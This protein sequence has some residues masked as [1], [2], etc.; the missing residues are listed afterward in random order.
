[1]T[2]TESLIVYA[3]SATN[4]CRLLAYLPQILLLLRDRGP[5]TATSGLSWGL[6][7]VSNGATALYAAVVVKRRWDG[8]FVCGQC[9]VLRGHRG[10]DSTPTAAMAPDRADR[11]LMSRSSG[12][13]QTARKRNGLSALGVSVG[14]DCLEA[15]RLRPDIASGSRSDGRPVPVLLTSRGN[16]TAC[17]ERVELREPLPRKWLQ[18]HGKR[19]LPTGYRAR[20]W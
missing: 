16:R 4:F 14:P 7:L 18:Q 3:F 19:P 5:A 13:R 8:N 10:A 20:S 12:R 11:G 17:T 6:F 9:S 1:M 15:L 2:I